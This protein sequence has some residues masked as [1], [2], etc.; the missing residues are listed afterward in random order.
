M[1][2]Q[3]CLRLDE[4][5]IEILERNAKQQGI[6]LRRYIRSTIEKGLV[7]DAQLQKGSTEDVRVI[8]DFQIRIAELITQNTI[9]SRR[10]LRSM[11]DSDSQA[12]QEIKN[13]DRD[14]KEYVSKLLQPQVELLR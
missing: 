4:K 7:I 8:N 1:M 6:K 9:L 2:K 10:L 13:A 3:L 5:L 12:E 11:A 14:S